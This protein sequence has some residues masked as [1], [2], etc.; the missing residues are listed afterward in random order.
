MCPK[1]D[2]WDFRCIIIMVF[3]TTTK[4]LREAQKRLFEHLFL[5]FEGKNKWVFWKT[6]KISEKIPQLKMDTRF[7]DTFCSKRTQNET[8]KNTIKILVW[9]KIYTFFLTAECIK[10]VVK[11]L[12]KPKTCEPYPSQLL[13]P[14]NNFN[15]KRPK[16]IKKASFVYSRHPGFPKK[17][18]EYCQKCR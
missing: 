5:T 18:V 13:W 14:A 6:T 4:R 1:T 16:I 8:Q 15:Y 7:F 12:F 11:Q 17:W 10:L 2:F 3:E 9:S